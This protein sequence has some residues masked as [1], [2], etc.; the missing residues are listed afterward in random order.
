MVKDWKIDYVGKVS[1]DMTK[2]K[3][4]GL[5]DVKRMP[6]SQ[7][8]EIRKAL[9]GHGS[10]KFV[11]KSLVKKAL[12]KNKLPLLDKLPEK[13]IIITSDLDAFEL[14]RI[15]KAHRHKASAKSGMISTEKIIVPKGGTGLPPGQA[16]ADL[17]GAGIPSKIAKGQIEVIKDHVIL[18]EGDVVTPQIA[19][20]LSTLDIKPFE[21][22]LEVSAILEE[23]TIFTSD[24][25]DVNLD[26]I[27]MK[28]SRASTEAFSLALETVYPTKEVVE[29][30]LG[31]LSNQ[32]KNMAL[33][34][35]WVTKDTINQIIGKA[36][37]HANSL[38]GTI[39][40]N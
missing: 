27:R 35:D 18:N 17:Q 29:V 37:A 11:K 39:G 20:A 19:T 10:V 30:L 7:I 14:F 21:F 26:E 38:K 24:V 32:A 12:E 23:G 28:F 33:E 1:E 6:S 8:Q 34:L 9:R 40:G 2:A 4:L 5:A 13:V 36:N 16:I 22:G 3:T 15:I 31:R 25:L